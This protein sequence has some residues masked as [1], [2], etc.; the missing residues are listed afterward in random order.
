[1]GCDTLTNV[2]G[3]T[4]DANTETTDSLGGDFGEVNGGDD[5]GET[6]TKTGDES[7]SEQLGVVTRLVS[8]VDT[9]RGHPDGS[10]EDPEQTGKHRGSQTTE[11]VAEEES[12]S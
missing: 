7:A 5:G 1:M 10:T 6:D 4:E 12:D 11:T 3:T 8:A 2:N 9:G